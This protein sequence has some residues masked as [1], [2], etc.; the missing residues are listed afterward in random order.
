MVSVLAG[1]LP[2][3]NGDGWKPNFVIENLSLRKPLPSDDVK[4][5]MGQPSLGLNYI[6]ANELQL[7]ACWH[8][9]ATALIGLGLLCPSV[10]PGDTVEVAGAVLSRRVTS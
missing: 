10:G 1:K 8:G 7:P 2:P 9:S 3:H 6:T 4:A 5:L